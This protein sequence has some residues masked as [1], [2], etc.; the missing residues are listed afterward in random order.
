MRDTHIKDKKKV[1]FSFLWRIKS[2]TCPCESRSNSYRDF[3]STRLFMPKKQQ[4]KR[5]SK[6]QLKQ[7]LSLTVTAASRARAEEVAAREHRSVS[8]LFEHLVALEF[9]KIAGAKSKRRS[10]PALA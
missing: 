7:K 5:G 6:R 8:S 2:E 3:S 1:A 9:E 10:N 4:S